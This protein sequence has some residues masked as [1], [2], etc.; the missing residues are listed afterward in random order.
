MDDKTKL[1]KMVT[2]K[3]GE[4]GRR[5]NIVV[6]ILNETPNKKEPEFKVQIDN[7]YKSLCHE[8]PRLRN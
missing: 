8:S 6:E 4:N 1:E 3:T 7:K 5:H 2:L